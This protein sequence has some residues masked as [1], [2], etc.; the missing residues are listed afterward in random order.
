MIV[1]GRHLHLN[2]RH[3]SPN[4][5]TFDCRKISF[6]F[7]VCVFI[8]DDSK[9]RALNFQKVSGWIHAQK[10]TPLPRKKTFNHTSKL[11]A[12]VL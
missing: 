8:A 10:V 1:I 11:V 12:V 5:R 2:L 4:A 6:R 9:D 7:H 3:L